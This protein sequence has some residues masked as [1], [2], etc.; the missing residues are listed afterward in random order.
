VARESLPRWLA[1]RFFL[2]WMPARQRRFDWASCL[3]NI[4]RPG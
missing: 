1:G 2:P 4:A 3:C